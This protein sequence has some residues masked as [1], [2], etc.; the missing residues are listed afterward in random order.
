M[1]LIPILRATSTA[2]SGPTCTASWANQV[3]TDLAVAWYML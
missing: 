1:L 3:F 2:R